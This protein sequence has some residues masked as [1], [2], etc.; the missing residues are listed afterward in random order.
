M[1]QPNADAG[2]PPRWWAAS[3]GYEVYLASYADSDGDGLGDLRG[4]RSRLE[5]LEQL[6]VDLLWITP[7]Y[8][9]P[10]RDNGYDVSDYR[11]VHPRCGTL[12]DLDELLADAHGRGMRVVIDLVVNHTSSEHAWFTASRS[13]V[14]NRYRDYYVWRDAAPGGGPPNNWVSMFG[15]PAWSWDEATGQYWLHLFLPEQPDLNWS[16]PRVADE[17]DS[18]L[19]FWLDRGV[20]GLRVDTA[21]M[22]VKNPDLTDNPPADERPG[23]VPTGT[24]AGWGTQRHVHDIDQPGV[25]EVHRRW[26]HVTAAYDALLLGEVYLMDPEDVARYVRA[27]DGLDVSFLFTPV[28]LDWDPGALAA[29]LRRATA[30]VGGHPLFAWVLSSHDSRRAVTRYGSGAQGR[31]RA[32]L[33]HTLLFTLPGLPF[34]YQGEELGLEDGDVPP[35][36]ARDPI[37]RVA[38]EHGSSRDRARTPMPW[39]PGPE[40]GGEPGLEVWLWG[41]KGV[42]AVCPQG[43]QLS[44]PQSAAVIR[45]LH[46]PEVR[47]WSIEGHDRRPAR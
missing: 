38:G 29:V 13:S 5:H 47:R 11:G 46:Q 19:R 45:A 3:V 10:L 23:R 22:F 43:R 34:L 8:P 17:V 14:E 28:E 41:R 26:R 40:G 44:Q 20:D 30:A 1:G 6:G 16:D 27:G 12:P 42:L 4:L 24:V 25:L 39:C 7:F 31:E 21:H 36:A 37:G 35:G 2:N 32:L 15:G 18:I 33:V 9:S